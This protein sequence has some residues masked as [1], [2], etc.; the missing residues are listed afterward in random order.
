MRHYAFFPLVIAFFLGLCT[1][2]NAQDVKPAKILVFTRSQSFEHEPAKLLDDGTTATGRILNAYFAENNKNIEIVETQDGGVFDG[3]IDQYDAFVFNTSG[4]LLDPNDSKN[5][6][7]KAM[8]EAGLRKMFAAVQ[9]GKGFV[10]I[11]SATDTHCTLRDEEGKDLYTK[12]IGARFT[13]HGDQQ[14]ATLTVVEPT[15]FPSLKNI[16]GKITTRDEWYAMNQFAK[17][18]HVVLIQ[19]TGAMHGRDYERPPYPATWIRKEGKGRVAYTSFGHDNRYFTEQV[20]RIS[21]L[22][23]WAVRRFEADTTPNIEKVTPD[24]AKMPGDQ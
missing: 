11:H 22:I 6:K 17:D 7:A 16:D 24:Y 18:I 23:E 13:S 9:S 19:E 14:T 3:D 10:G 20:A 2:L 21:D 5:D 1:L 15:P 4:N 12:F 8:T